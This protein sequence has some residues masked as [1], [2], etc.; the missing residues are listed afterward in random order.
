MFTEVFRVGLLRKNQTYIVLIYMAL[1][2][3]FYSNNTII[4]LVLELSILNIYA[5]QLLGIAFFL[6]KSYILETKKS[7]I[8]VL[9][10]NFEHGLFAMFTS[11]MLL[12]V[13]NFSPVNR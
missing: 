7:Y 2:F 8:G 1:Q 10:Q 5:S 4:I 9:F 12:L 6:V 3:R 11:C 13:I